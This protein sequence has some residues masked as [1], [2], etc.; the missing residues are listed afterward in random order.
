VEKTA[1]GFFL[2]NA[3]DAMLRVF[4]LKGQLLR[5]HSAYFPAGKN[6]VDFDFGGEQ[7]SGVLYYELA[8]PFGV[9][10]RKMVQRK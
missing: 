2:P 1:I 7:A 9:A 8:T 3:C 6:T 5:E 4:D 10:A